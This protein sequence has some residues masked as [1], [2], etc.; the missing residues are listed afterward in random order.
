VQARIDPRGHKPVEVAIDEVEQDLI[1][2]QQK[3]ENEHP[4]EEEG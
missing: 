1:Q 3:G 4:E 2:W